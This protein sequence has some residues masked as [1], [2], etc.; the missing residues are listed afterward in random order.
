MI[1]YSIIQK[2][3]LEGA[4]RLD[5]EYYQPE[6]LDIIKNLDRLKAIPIKE[7]AKNPK[8]K[9]K[10]KTGETFNYIEISEVDLSTGEYNKS[11]IL[12][13]NTPDRA[14]WVVRANDVIV[15]TVRPIRNAVSLV[16][17]DD[18]NLVCSSGFAVLEA[19]KIEPEYLFVYLKTQPVVNLL[20]R[21]TTAT[22]YP[23]VTIDDILDIKIYLSNESFR[24]EIKNRVI[25]SQKELEKSKIFYSQAEDLL[26]EE[27]GLKDYKIDDELSCVVSFSETK[28]VHRIDAEY[29]QPKYEKIISKIKKQNVKLLGDLVSLKKGIEP[30]ADEYQ[31]EGK[32]FI[33][34]SSLSK[35]GLVD[36]DQKYLS[37]VLYN[38]LRKN[39]EPKQ[40]EILLTK[41]ATPGIAYLLKEP[42]EGIV[43]GG[44]VRLK[45]KE[46]VEPEYISLC[47]NSIVGQMQIERDAGGSIII[48]L[49]PEQIKNLQ[50]PVLSKSVQQKITDLVNKSHESHKKAKELLAE[51]K[52]KVE[53][54]IET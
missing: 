7:I 1:T 15:S 43:A 47:I 16:N 23:A 39:Y 45:V 40:S 24:K 46:D 41:D 38:E 48:H 8:R 53:Q 42:V 3:Q 14:Q 51:A 4:K 31:D 29:F 50:I 17:E 20:D 13:E 34:V 2:S 25:E 27:L 9:F 35:Q 52:Q 12:G 33:R 19:E 37:D 10:P 18:K 28:D 36:K 54:I 44:I 5:A 11:E 30:G 49:K 32:L 22:M 26:L 6:Y 21:L